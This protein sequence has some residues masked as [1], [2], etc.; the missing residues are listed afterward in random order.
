MAAVRAVDIFKRIGSR[1]SEGDLFR[2]AFI[3]GVWKD[4]HSKQTFP[5]CNPATGEIITEVS[6]MGKDDVLEA[7]SHAHTA[8][9]K[10]RSTTAKV[11]K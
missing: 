4:A 7:I 3:G 2:K 6:D 8:Q 5:V 1:L 11:S 10:W 9:K